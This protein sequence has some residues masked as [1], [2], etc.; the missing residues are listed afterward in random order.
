L[1]LPLKQHLFRIQNKDKTIFHA[2]TG[3]RS[4][5]KI[6]GHKIKNEHRNML[7]QNMIKFDELSKFLITNELYSVI[8]KLK[9]MTK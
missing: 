2:P 4:D 1:L 5:W 6:M 7:E 8:M 3:M 9:F